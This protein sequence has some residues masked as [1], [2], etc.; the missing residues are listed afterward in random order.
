MATGSDFYSSSV[1]PSQFEVGKIYH[2]ETN[3]RGS[4]AKSR[5]VKILKM[6]MKL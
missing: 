4:G 6:T 5:H 3:S 1:D 2:I